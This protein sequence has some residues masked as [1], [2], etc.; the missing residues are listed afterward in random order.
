ME[1]R[2]DLSAAIAQV[3]SQD[4]VCFV[5]ILINKGFPLEYVMDAIERMRNGP[6]RFEDYTLVR[7]AL[8]DSVYL[9]DDD[10]MN[11]LHEHLPSL[12]EKYY[13]QKKINEEI[14]DLIEWYNNE[15][16]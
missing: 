8:R 7:N 12:F 15:Q 14:K 2:E 3:Y 13:N 6:I 9:Y 10:Q 16:D 5:D 4:V 1:D 11:F